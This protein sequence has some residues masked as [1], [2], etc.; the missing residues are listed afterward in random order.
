M[1]DDLEARLA[2]LRGMT[3][4]SM[5]ADTVVAADRVRL[6]RQV[7]AGVV[8]GAVGLAGAA[9]GAVLLTRGQGG[10]PAPSITAVPSA[11]SPT[12]TP[13][14]TPTTTEPMTPTG[15]PT[16]VP[17]PSLTPEPSVSPTPE[18]TSA[19]PSPQT[20]SASPSR[21]QGRCLGEEANGFC[22]RTSAGL[23]AVLSADGKMTTLFSGRTELVSVYAI[24]GIGGAGM[25]EEPIAVTVVRSTPT[26]YRD[27]AGNSTYAITSVTEYRNGTAYVS[28]NLTITRYQ[29]GKPLSYWDFS[30]KPPVLRDLETLVMSD[31]RPAAV[32]PLALARKSATSGVE[33]AIYDAL[34]SAYNGK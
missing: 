18:G 4:S 28:H 8:A 31:P 2:R 17:T 25:D 24:G 12:A 20:P 29:V 1:S 19:S 32:M 3:P 26:R 5:D 22:L 9:T 30:P 7:L 15:T 21:K 10:G 27:A 33:A 11:A 6:R 14:V 23:R 16:S 34:A 13:S